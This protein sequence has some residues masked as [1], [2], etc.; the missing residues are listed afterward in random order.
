MMSLSLA[1]RVSFLGF[2][3]ACGGSVLSVGKDHSADTGDGGSTD[4]GGGSKSCKSSSDCGAG[5]ACGFPEV[6]ACAASGT[7]FDVSGPACAAYSA[8]CACDGTEVNVACTNL[9]AGLVPAPLLH[10]G[11]CVKDGGEGLDAAGGPCASTA[12]CPSGFECGFPRA[13]ACLAKGACFDMRN[14]PVCDAYG[15]GCACDGT[16]INIACPPVPSGYL[17]K[18]LRHAG[19][20][21]D[22]GQ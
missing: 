6:A 9:P 11:G 20:C 4:G 12:D 10:R 8:A 17:S 7:C 1:L 5:F 14:V 21:N 16:E 3:A 18:P 13:D 19:P 15:A 2:L 22:A